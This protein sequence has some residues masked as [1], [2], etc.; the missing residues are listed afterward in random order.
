MFCSFPVS[1]GTSI[2]K[3][4]PPSTGY[5]CSSARCVK[6]AHNAV[7]TLVCFPFDLVDARNLK[8]KAWES[9]APTRLNLCAKIT[10]VVLS[11]AYLLYDTVR[12]DVPGPGTTALVVVACL[13]D[14]LLL[15]CESYSLYTT[16]LPPPVLIEIRRHALRDTS[17]QTVAAV[18]ITACEVCAAWGFGATATWA[19]ADA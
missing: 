14:L 15:G 19:G 8:K 12:Q 3:L 1:V 17:H 7:M 4:F 16:I 10:Q 11:L 13:S 6:V 2:G 9:P 5:M 18:W